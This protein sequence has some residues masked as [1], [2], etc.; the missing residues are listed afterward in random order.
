MTHIRTITDV[1]E[2][3]SRTR[4]AYGSGA[5]WNHRHRDVSGG[6]LR[7]IVFGAVEGLVTNGSLIAGVGWNAPRWS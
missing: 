4:E 6:K 2:G 3:T 1:A 7:P 5:R